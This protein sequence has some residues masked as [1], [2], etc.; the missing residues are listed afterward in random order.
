MEWS[1][2][3]KE[4][5]SPQNSA[6]PSL[7]TKNQGT[8]YSSPQFKLHFHSRIAQ[9]AHSAM[10]L[11]RRAQAWRTPP[12][13]DRRRARLRRLHPA[14]VPAGPPRTPSDLTGSILIP[15]IHFHLAIIPPRRG[16][17]PH[18][19]GS[20]GGGLKRAADMVRLAS[21]T[22]NKLTH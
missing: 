16:R 12:A 22:P 15:P 11:R 9:S 8:R 7:Q 10:L 18:R 21:C 6:M 13:A 20:Q 19:T 4:A 5:A 1:V 3:T 14:A 2:H 17:S